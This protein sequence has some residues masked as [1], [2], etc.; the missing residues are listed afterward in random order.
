MNQ[1]EHA[2]K[3]GRWFRIR[4]QEFLEV[5]Q[6]NYPLKTEEIR[7]KIIQGRKYNDRESNW[8]PLD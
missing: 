2:K 6:M 5:L 1:E 7:V 8:E 3:T 4:Y